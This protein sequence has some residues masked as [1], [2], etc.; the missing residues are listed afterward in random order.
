MCKCGNGPP[1]RFNP[2]MIRQ[3]CLECRKQDKADYKFL[4]TVSLIFLLLFKEW[5][6]ECEVYMLYFTERYYQDMEHLLGFEESLEEFW[7]T[8][9]SFSVGIEHFDNKIREMELLMTSKINKYWEV[10]RPNLIEVL[11]EYF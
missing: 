11:K 10:I 9:E 5:E 2:Q 7:E 1:P 4:K 3:D 6:V 8:E